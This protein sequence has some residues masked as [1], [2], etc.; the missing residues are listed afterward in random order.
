MRRCPRLINNGG[1]KFLYALAVCLL[2]TIFLFVNAA[3]PVLTQA[4]GS[5]PDNTSGKAIESAPDNTSASAAVFPQL[6]CSDPI[7]YAQTDNIIS[8]SD[9]AAANYFCFSR[10][11]YGL[12]NPEMSDGLSRAA[13]YGAFAAL[14]AERGT[15]TG[16]AA[17]ERGTETGS[18]GAGFASD[19]G[20]GGTFPDISGIFSEIDAIDGFA[21]VVFDDFTCL[22]AEK[23]A[24][25]TVDSLLDFSPLSRDLPKIKISEI[26]AFGLASA[27][28]QTASGCVYCAVICVSY[29]SIGGSEDDYLQELFPDILCISGEFNEFPKNGSTFPDI[30]ENLNGS[31]SPV[32]CAASDNQILYFD[33]ISAINPDTIA[34][35]SGIVNLRGEPVGVNLNRADI[36]RLRADN[37]QLNISM[38]FGGRIAGNTVDVAISSPSSVSAGGK[39]IV[40]PSI[41]ESELWNVIRYIDFPALSTSKPILCSPLAIGINDMAEPVSVPR[42]T[43]ATIIEEG[44]DGNYSQ[45]TVAIE[46]AGIELTPVRPMY[47][48]NK[49]LNVHI[50]QGSALSEDGHAIIAWLGNET[51]VTDIELPVIK[52][53]ENSENGSLAPVQTVENGSLAPVQTAENGSLAPVSQAEPYYVF[54]IE[55]PDGTVQAVKKN[56]PYAVWNPAKEGTTTLSAERY[57]ALGRL[58][59]SATIIINVAKKAEMVYSEPV[60]E[61]TA[62]EL[63]G[64]ISITET[65]DGNK[66]IRGIHAGTTAEA[67]TAI[68]V[69]SG[70]A[71][72]ELTVTKPDGTAIA[73]DAKVGTGA[74]IKVS[75]QGKVYHELYAVITGDVN[76]DGAVGIADF[77]KLR[78]HLLN[79]DVVNGFYV[80]AADLN[81]DDAIGVAD[82]AKLRQYLLGALELD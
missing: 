2:L 76:G 60:L 42:F 54:V 40:L 17:V 65:G 46:Y 64:S 82:F 55:S 68:F 56:D 36:D 10:R 15:E 45:T 29:D 41:P 72:P 57:D 21:C 24:K 28:R 8:A 80:Y 31:L 67:L 50:G 34:E 32:S 5:A 79:G 19:D 13:L 7:Y 11:L 39:T 38:T 1:G 23:S 22:N 14:C 59:G 3:T 4:S 26:K 6:F 43:Q 37:S 47:T 9:A 33:D 61:L 35:A 66:L 70:G 74:V 52:A 48:D 63:P 30:S 58:A 69:V 62:G 75:D 25:L 51:G 73:G 77:A 44:S 20:C 18:A 71:D 16:F 27:I 78:Q 81:R 49:G 12:N 53:P